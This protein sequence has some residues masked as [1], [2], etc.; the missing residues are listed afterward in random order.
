LRKIRIVHLVNGLGHDGTSKAVMELC[1]LFNGEQYEISVLSLSPNIELTESN[2]WPKNVSVYPYNFYAD[3]DYSLKRYLILFFIKKIIRERSK[4]VIKRIETIQPDILHCH[5]Q[6]RELIIA[7]Q[8][9]LQNKTQLLYTDHSVRLKGGQY[10]FINTWMLAWLYRKIYRR[11]HVVAVAKSVFNGHNKYHL[12]NK[13]KIHALIENKI[14]TLQFCPSP[15]ANRSLQ[16]V[17]VARLDNR[18]GH[19][20]LLAAWSKI[21]TSEK[22]ELVLVGGGELEAGLNSMV[23]VLQPKH[24]VIFTGAVENVLPYLQSAHIAVFPSLQEGLPLAL[25]EKMSCGLPVIASDIPEL[26]G[27]I[28]DGE[29]GLFFKTGDA[30]DLKEKLL[31]LVDNNQLRDYLG[32]RARQFVTEKY[33]Y[34]L[35]KKEYEVVYRDVLKK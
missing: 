26:Q 30:D 31:L 22:I 27:I 25:L 15:K 16:V 9:K 28:E 32:K 14:N 18:K 23:N 12:V 11:F 4:E 3:P 2:N 21:E 35:L 1:N 5:L 13:N 10:P 8:S 24:R 6:P 19:D 34:K 20:V 17:Y 33:D 7:L 29:N